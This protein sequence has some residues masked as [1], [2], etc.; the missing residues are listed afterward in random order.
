[1]DKIRESTIR[2]VG[3]LAHPEGGRGGSC[4]VP[5]GQV[6]FPF[7]LLDHMEREGMY[8]IEL[9]DMAQNV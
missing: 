2:L 7:S 5:T 8:S 6:N 1:M 4:S 9:L 3:A